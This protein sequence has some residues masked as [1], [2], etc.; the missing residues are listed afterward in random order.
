MRLIVGRIVG[1]IVCTQKD[2]SLTGQK[3]LV[4]QP[5]NI[6]TL[7]DEGAALVALD[8][9]GAG[10]TELVLVVGGSSARM[11]GGY[12]KTAVDQ[13]VIGIL[14]SIDILGRSVFRKEGN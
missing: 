9:V 4:I 5:V 10:Q 1:N 14:D 11:A 2:K 12:E 7:K 6:A 8:S 13:A 3:M